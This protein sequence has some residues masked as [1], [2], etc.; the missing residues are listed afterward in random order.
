MS[1]LVLILKLIINDCLDSGTQLPFI[2]WAQ[3]H[4]FGVIVA[5]PNLNRAK[6]ERVFIRGSSSPEEHMETLWT[7][8]V[9]RSKAK[10]I[11]IV[12]HSYGGVSTLELAENH[13]DDFEKRV[14]AVAL[15]DSVHKFSHQRSTDRLINFY[16]QR[17][18]N[19]ASAGPQDPLDSP[20]DSKMDFC[21]TVSAGTDRHDYTSY[22]SMKSIFK[23]IEEQFTESKKKMDIESKSSSVDPVPKADKD[24]ANENVKKS[25]DSNANAAKSESS[26]GETTEAASN[27]Q[28]M[29]SQEDTEP[30]SQDTN[31]Q[32]NDVDMDSQGPKSP[33]SE[34]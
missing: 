25:T 33:K 30:M 26:S 14:R 5:N 8:F 6:G 11:A 7:D 24:K 23:F 17:A 28:E 19:W 20:L 18:K 31:S 1:L 9:A 16:Q 32:A 13:L 2:K 15:T 21:P 29:L 12:A 10:D 22:S 3:E 27:T 4:G 34:L